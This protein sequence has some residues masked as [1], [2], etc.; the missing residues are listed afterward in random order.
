M[1]WHPGTICGQRS[2]IPP[3]TEGPQFGQSYP[4]R[5]STGLRYMRRAVDVQILTRSYISC[6]HLPVETASNILR[7]MQSGVPLFE[8]SLMKIAAACLTP[9]SFLVDLEIMETN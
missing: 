9:R 6:H 4:H 2:H 7:C 8:A 5:K 1:P 3:A